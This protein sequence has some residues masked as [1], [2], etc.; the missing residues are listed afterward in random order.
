MTKQECAIIMA[1]TGICML[2]GNE[3]SVFHEYIEKLMN[4][5]V[6]THELANKEVWE[7]IKKKSE[8]DFMNIC[9]EAKS[10]GWINC[11]ERPPEENGRYLVRVKS[12]DGTADIYF[13]TVDN[14]SAGEWLINEK[15]KGFEKKVTHW[16][17][18]PEY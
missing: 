8:D 2:T 12:S 1:Y 13:E 4:R 11:E 10:N 9:K 18:V 16:M 17:D 5:P 6:Y 3:F 14:Y 15:S 7:E